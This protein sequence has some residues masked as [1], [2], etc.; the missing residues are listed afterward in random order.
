MTTSTWL[1]AILALVLVIGG[2]LSPVTT[3]AQAPQPA[4]TQGPAPAEPGDGAAVG[5]ALLN[6]IH[7]PGKAILCATGTVVST[8]LMLLT[9]GSAYRAAVALFNEGCAGP[10]ALTASDVRGQRQFEERSH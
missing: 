5:A 8:G 6:V 2:V 10:W 4:M 1:C 9:F 7:V 3:M